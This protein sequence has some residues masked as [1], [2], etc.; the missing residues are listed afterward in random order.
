[1]GCTI[2]SI[3]AYHGYDV[4]LCDQSE[5]AL[6]SFEQRAAPIAKVF[7]ESEQEIHRI[8]AKVQKVSDLETAVA[9]AFM[10]H[11]VVQ[12]DLALKQEIFARLDE[13]LADDVVLATNT[14]SYLLT[15]ISKKCTNKARVIGIHYITPAHIVKAVE[16]I[17]ADDTDRALIP[18]TQ[19]FL[20][21]ID[22]V[23]I[24][25]K[26]RPSFIVNRLQYALLVEAYKLLQEG[27]TDAA[28]IDTAVRLSLG[29]RLALWG[30]LM[31]EDLVVNKSTVLSSLQYLNQS[32]EDTD[33]A[34]GVPESLRERVASGALGALVGQGW[35]AWPKPYE[36]IVV[37][38]DRQLHS[39]L[40]WLDNE[41]A[42]K[43]LG[44]EPAAGDKNK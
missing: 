12:E 2:A 14:S 26:E 39:L 33:A 11:E 29:P 15:E 35:Y 21:S 23:G 18:W 17:Y 5:A 22:H 25:C 30:P 4:V 32:A 10:V 44:A 1:M 20:K 24:V 28:N 38:R 13:L 6:A 7:C 16:I 3:Y 36:D 19:D 31:T 41:D 9:N 27:Y 37:T 8:L 34:T 40:Q 42:V 43:A